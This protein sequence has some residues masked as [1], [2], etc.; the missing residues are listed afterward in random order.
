M[1]GK[2]GFREP[3]ASILS[4][5]KRVDP[6]QEIQCCGSYE[7]KNWTAF[8]ISAPEPT[9]REV[10]PNFKLGTVTASC[11][12]SFSWETPKRWHCFFKGSMARGACFQP[13]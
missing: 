1:N 5:L 2:L 3:F 9:R 4:R 13:S 6:S 11:L 12:G 8:A 10:V 7:K